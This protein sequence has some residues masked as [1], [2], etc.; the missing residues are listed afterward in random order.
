M[1]DLY[2]H[3]ADQ[4]RKERRENG[5]CVHDQHPQFCSRC[6]ADA[7]LSQ[8]DVESAVKAPRLE[9]LTGGEKIHHFL[10]SGLMVGDPCPYCD[11]GSVPHQF[12]GGRVL[13][14]CIICKGWG[15]LQECGHRSCYSRGGHWDGCDYE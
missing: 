1:A 10:N 7:V 11:E 2:A 6:K 4:L 9:F 14:R 15:R 13:V 12:R 8:S 5:W 3:G